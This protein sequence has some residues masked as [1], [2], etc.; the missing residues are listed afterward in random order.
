TRDDHGNHALQDVADQREYRGELAT[1]AQHVGGA[2]IFRSNLAR[3]LQTHGTRDDDGSG[4]GTQQIGEQRQE[5]DHG[6]LLE[7]SGLSPSSR[8]C[9]RRGARSA[10]S[11]SVI[12]SFI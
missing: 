1:V 8:I 2:G 7:W 3:V 9:A 4:N 11:V 10:P 12:V 6:A 5:V